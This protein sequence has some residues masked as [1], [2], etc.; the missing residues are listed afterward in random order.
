[1]YKVTRLWGVPGSTGKKEL[2]VAEEGRTIG[3]VQCLHSETEH[4]L[5]LY[6]QIFRQGEEPCILMGASLS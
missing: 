1:M 6:N 5:Y 2:V 3:P 4:M